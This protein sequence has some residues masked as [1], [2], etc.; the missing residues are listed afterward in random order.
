[1]ITIAHD[2]PPTEDVSTI[3]N[4]AVQYHQLGQLRQAEQRYSQLLDI[5]PE[6][7]QLWYLLGMLARQ[8]NRL[9]RAA[10]CL[11]RAITFSRAGNSTYHVALGTVYQQQQ[12]LEAARTQFQQALALPPPDPTTHN[13]LGVVLQQLDRQAEALAQHQQAIDLA[14]RDPVDA[15]ILA[16]SYNNAG[17]VH[18]TQQQWTQARQSFQ[19][20]ISHQPDLA[21]AHY[22]LGNCLLAQNQ[23]EQAAHCFQQTL[24]L[25]P[26]YLKAYI[27]L[28]VT[29]QKQGQ[30]EAA[31]L[32][33]QHALTLD[34]DNAT[35]YNNLSQMLPTESDPPDNSEQTARAY[36]EQGL[37]LGELGQFEAA[38]QAFE[39]ALTVRPQQPEIYSNLGV[40]LQN[41]GRVAEAVAHFRQALALDPTFYGA[42]SNLLMALH[43]LPQTT[44]A[45]LNLAHEQWGERFGNRAVRLNADGHPAILQQKLADISTDRSP[46]AAIR[47][48]YISPDF[49]R[50]PV[51]FFIEPI[52]ANH[53]PH[54]FA[55]TCYS[56]V[57]VPD[58]M[59]ARLKQW[60]ARW[61]EIS[62]MSD[63][64]V[65]D[66][67]RADGID[68]L[69]ELAGHTANNRLMVLAQKPAPVQVSYLGYPTMTGLPAIDHW[70]T[71]DLTAN[72][73]S[74][75]PPSTAEP[76]APC[77]LCYAPPAEAPP[78]NRLPAHTRGYITFGSLNHLPKVSDT[79]LTMW[80]QILQ[81]LPNARLILK[82]IPLSDEPTRQR[83]LERLHR[84]GLPLERVAL[85]GY[86]E[87]LAE[88]LALYHDIDVALDTFPYNGTTTTCES[89]WMGVPVISLV[90]D[91]H[92]G[93]VGL[94]LLNTLGLGEWVTQTAEEYIRVAIDLAQ[95]EQAMTHVAELRATLRNRM[96]QSPLCDGPTFTRKLEN[97]YRRWWEATA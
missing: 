34:P 72:G 39:Q 38:A 93:R 44:L 10:T 57:A 87:G 26:N 97:L 25:N 51:A 42:H 1:M 4:Q 77:F 7:A 54:R 15:R 68:I 73:S 40:V 49:R 56:D 41:Q 16:Q 8:Q 37:L 55:I 36:H 32:A 90:G 22:N 21:T 31:R 75:H 2:A 79:V 24:E 14:Q 52:L 74:A 64:E 71:D 91:H 33:Y 30:L 88:H 89:L 5:S 43:Y 47:I 6:Q 19:R 35:A 27:N 92:A 9:E 81:T 96:Q 69:I 85:H 46:T 66:L 62:P 67:I 84:L 94:S 13:R 80:A 78:V 28:G 53:D 76:L 48:G 50:H 11:Q 61:R 59:T 70:L 29:R 3:F 12:Q 83:L 45:D 63:D 23:L 60:P 86:V 65:A 82:T 58:K 17:L 18:Q 95:S 20:A